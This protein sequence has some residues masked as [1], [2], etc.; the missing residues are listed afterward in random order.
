MFLLIALLSTACHE[1]TTV[2]LDGDYDASTDSLLSLFSTL[3]P[4]TQEISKSDFIKSEVLLSARNN[5]ISNYKF[6][7]SFLNAIKTAG[8]AWPNLNKKNEALRSFFANDTLSSLTEVFTDNSKR[9]ANLY[10][11]LRQSCLFMIDGKNFS[12]KLQANTDP[13]QTKLGYNW[14]SKQYDENAIPCNYP[15]GSNKLNIC[16]KKFYGLDC[17]GFV[18]QAFKLSGL[19]FGDKPEDFANAAYFS[20]RSH[21]KKVLD[22]YFECNGGCYSVERISYTE[23]KDLRNGDIII[24]QHKTSKKFFHIAFCF[25]NIDYKTHADSLILLESRGDPKNN[26]NNNCVPKRGPKVTYIDNKETRF[27]TDSTNI[28]IVR[29]SVK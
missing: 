2:A 20:D 8:S 18:Y 3:D 14:G 16:Q 6:V 24:F 12:K 1:E 15:G 28:Y 25:E 13:K 26:C 10:D 5:G 7:Q 17:S 23:T 11:T 4:S 9:L 22:K 27:N 19:N 21:Y 29:I